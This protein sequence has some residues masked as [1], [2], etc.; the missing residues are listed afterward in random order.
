MLGDA[1]EP[2]LLGS[3]KGNIGHTNSAAGVASLIKAV[4]AVAHRAVPA[5]LHA[6]P[7]NPALRLDGSRFR[8][9]AV[10]APWTGPGHAGVSSF[11]IGGTNAHVVLGPARTGRRPSTTPG[12]SC[13]ACPPR[14]PRPPGRPPHGWPPP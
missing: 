9:P 11:G 6:E 4:L 10:S 5:T 13:C 14:P 8:L 7:A 1:G 12:R 3:V 2:C